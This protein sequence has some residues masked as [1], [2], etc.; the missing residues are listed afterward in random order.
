MFELKVVVM[1]D[2]KGTF[3][4]TRDLIGDRLFVLGHRRPRSGRKRISFLHNS[5]K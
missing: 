5:V 1:P 3:L 4:Q 2:Q